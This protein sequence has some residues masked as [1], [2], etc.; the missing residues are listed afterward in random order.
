MCTIYTF[1]KEFYNEHK[2]AIVEQIES[3]SSFNGHGYSM[4]AIGTDE[5]TTELVRTMNVT[6][7][8][9]S[10][11]RLLGSDGSAER[12]W[13]HLRYSTTDFQGLNGCHGFAAGDYTVFHNGILSRRGS[14]SFNV[15]SELIAYDIEASGIEGAIAAIAE[16]ESYVNAMLVNNQTGTYSIIRMK[17]GSLH[18]DGQGNYSTSPIDNTPICHAVP[19]N[20]RTDYT[21][22]IVVPRPA[23]NYRGYLMDN[24]RYWFPR[25]NADA[26]WYEDEDTIATVDR[27][28]GSFN[29]LDISLETQNQLWAFDE[30]ETAEEFGQ[31]A[32]EYMF[33]TCGFPESLYRNLDVSQLVWFER[34]GFYWNPDAE[35]EQQ[36]NDYIDSQ[37]AIVDADAEK[38]VSTRKGA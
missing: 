16:S 1:G 14:A 9:A 4:L 2:V 5:G 28:S 34:C 17:S 35:V 19:T 10:L 24:E 31:V 3:D 13:I 8:L 21:T 32:E 33:D 38:T 18:T 26:V 6:S 27:G 36:L 30:C 29:D 25:R 15:D 22:A 20:T 12:A 11:D 37:E 23:I 7:L